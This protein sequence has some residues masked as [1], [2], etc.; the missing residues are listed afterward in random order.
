MLLR[1]L[2]GVYAPST[3]HIDI[4]GRVSP[5]FSASPGVDYDGTG[6]E[7][8]ITCGMY[9]GMSSEEVDENLCTQG[10]VLPVHSYTGLLWCLCNVR[11]RIRSGFYCAASPRT[12]AKRSKPKGISGNLHGTSQD[13]RRLAR[14]R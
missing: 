13:P 8:L 2:A 11:A 6:Y 12:G 9:L 7:N 14:S 3:G 10:G 4:D 5:L 1:V